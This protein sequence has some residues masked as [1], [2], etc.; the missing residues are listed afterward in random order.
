[1]FMRV[2]SKCAHQVRPPP[3]A[4]DAWYGARTASYVR[5]LARLLGR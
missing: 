5:A 4:V 3:M 2:S 1:M